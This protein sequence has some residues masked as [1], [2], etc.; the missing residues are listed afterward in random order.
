MSV[1]KRLYGWI[2]SSGFL[3]DEKVSDF[4]HTDIS[5]GAT[6]IRV[7]GD[8]SVWTAFF[9]HYC[10]DLLNDTHHFLSEIADPAVFR[11]FI[12]IDLKFDANIQ[13]LIGGFE[14]AAI[15][16]ACFA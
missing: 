4:T 10:E 13:V 16:C 7:D 15:S 14:D 9:D 12:D 2:E 6:R 5:G 8:E 1:H 11:A 3:P